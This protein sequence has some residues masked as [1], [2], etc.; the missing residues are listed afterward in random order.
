MEKTWPNIFC[1]D[2]RWWLQ[3]CPVDIERSK[4]YQESSNEI[5][6]RRQIPSE[7][8]RGRFPTMVYL[9]IF[10]HFPYLQV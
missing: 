7:W 8:S 3:V 10:L 1:R 5:R 4:A 2:L 6:A 9:F